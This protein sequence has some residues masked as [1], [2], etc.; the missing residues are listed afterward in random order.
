MYFHLPKIRKST[1]FTIT[2]FVQ[3]IPFPG[4]YTPLPPKKNHIFDKT[5]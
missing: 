5:H 3:H 2:Y 1:E 4:L